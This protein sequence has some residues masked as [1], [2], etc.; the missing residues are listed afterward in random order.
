MT[1]EPRTKE[2]ARAKTE[3]PSPQPLSR[4]ARGVRN[5]AELPAENDKRSLTIR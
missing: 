1:I 2:V 4:K 3:Q 5:V